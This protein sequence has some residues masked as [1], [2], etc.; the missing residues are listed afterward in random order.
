MLRTTRRACLA[1]GLGTAA[2]W[3]SVC[4]AATATV[5]RDL[6]AFDEVEFFAAGELTVEQTQREHLSL[7]AD[8]E[9]LRMITSEV[10]SRRLTIGLAPGRVETRAPIRLRLE[11]RS[12]RAFELR[13]SGNVRFGALRSDALALALTGAG[14]VRFDRLDT[15]TLAVRIA[16]VGHVRYR[17]N[18]VVTRSISGIGS[19]ERDD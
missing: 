18:P 7:E 4:A 6:A 1:L 11:L 17:G 9:V 14:N 3:A 2:A 15:P 12:L 8:P 13:G 10:H 16:G 5:E 19:V